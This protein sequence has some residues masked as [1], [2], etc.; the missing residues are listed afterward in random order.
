MMRIVLLLIVTFSWAVV[1]FET[2]ASFNDT[3]FPHKTEVELDGSQLILASTIQQRLA[4]ASH[5]SS[6]DRTSDANGDA[7]KKCPTVGC[8][9]SFCQST[10]V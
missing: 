2:H 8:C 3:V 10:A 9:I 1:G 5:V 6:R 4:E 7:A